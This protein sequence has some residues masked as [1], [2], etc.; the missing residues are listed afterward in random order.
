[1]CLQG[2]DDALVSAY[3][4]GAKRN[5]DFFMREAADDGL[6]EFGYGILRCISGTCDPC[7]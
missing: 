4:T 6:I 5:V 2:G 3:Y 1:M 7:L